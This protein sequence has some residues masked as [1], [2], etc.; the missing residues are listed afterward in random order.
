[1]RVLCFFPHSQQSNCCCYC[2]KWLSICKV[3]FFSLAKWKR[4]KVFFFFKFKN[5]TETQSKK[6][7]F[8]FVG[9]CVRAGALCVTQMRDAYKTFLLERKLTLSAFFFYSQSVIH[10]FHLHAYRTQ[11]MWCSVANLSYLHTHTHS[12][13][14]TYLLIKI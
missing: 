2:I 11:C 7:V 4:G 8:R 12:L 14:H 13:A 6:K 1:M 3:F 10:R 9:V 5:E